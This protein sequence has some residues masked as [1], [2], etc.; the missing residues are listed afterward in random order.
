MDKQDDIKDAEAEALRE[1]HVSIRV[2]S[3][4]EA[5]T[6]ELLLTPKDL[7]WLY[8]FTVT[9]GNIDSILEAQLAK[10]L[11]KIEE[12]IQVMPECL[13]A[14]SLDRPGLARMWHE[15][16][17]EGTATGANK[18]DEAGLD[19]PELRKL[20]EGHILDYHE[21]MS[22]KGNKPTLSPSSRAREI[23]AQLSKGGK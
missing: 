5:L 21:D 4:E 6:E 11:Q 10:V 19:R 9:K 20:I 3:K 1:P 13:E 15:N 18:P 16:K 7:P 2:L 23:L 12:A 17:T 14:E 8:D 22:K